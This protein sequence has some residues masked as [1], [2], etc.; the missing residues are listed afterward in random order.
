VD[1]RFDMNVKRSKQIRRVFDADK[2]GEVLKK[3]GMR[4]I[5]KEKKGEN[6]CL[7]SEF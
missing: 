1:L 3:K 6:T 7:P 4:R 5:E 2:S